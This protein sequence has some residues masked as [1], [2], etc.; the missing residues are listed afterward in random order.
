MDIEFFDDEQRFT[1]IYL[2]GVD[3]YCTHAWYIHV[4]KKIAQPNLNGFENV[5]WF[6]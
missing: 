1:F 2:D 4:Q 3:V 5:Y 6:G